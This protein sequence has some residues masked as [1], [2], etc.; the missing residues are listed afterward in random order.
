MKVIAV[1]GTPGTGKTT[2]SKKY[3]KEHDFT[4]V[5]VKMV[6]EEKGL[7]EGLDEKRDSKIIDTDRLNKALIEIIGQEREKNS[8]GIVIDSHLSHYLPKEHVDLVIITKCDLKTLRK[9]LEDR[10]YSK[11][12]VRENLDA[13]IFDVCRIEALEAGHEVEVVSTD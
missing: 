12:K 9:R 10:G 7:A 13:E 1:S 8:K 3:A 11:E 2:Y 6:I 4:Y 5:D